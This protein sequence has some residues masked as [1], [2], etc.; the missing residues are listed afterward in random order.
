M[1]NEDNQ[2][3]SFITFFFFFFT[4]NHVLNPAFTVAVN[5][6]KPAL[7]RGQMRAGI[8]SAVLRVEKRGGL[9]VV[10]VVEGKGGEGRW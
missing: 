10:V 2:L 4:P 7:R 8:P 9:T 3:Q 1:I 5:L 6:L